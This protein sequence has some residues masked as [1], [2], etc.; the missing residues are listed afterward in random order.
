MQ[1]RSE[2]TRARW[3]KR[4]IGGSIGA[5]VLLTAT[6]AQA[7]LFTLSGNTPPALS[8]SV[9]ADGITLTITGQFRI[10]PSWVD[11]N[12]TQ[13]PGGLGLQG[14]GNA[15]LDSLAVNEF[16][17][18]SITGLGAGERLA[19]D[20][21][22]FFELDSGEDFS[23]YVDSDPA[24]VGGQTLGPG[25]APGTNPWVLADNLTGA[26][27]IASTSF[28][29]KVNGGGDSFRIRAITAHVVPEPASAT[30]LALGLAGLGVRR[31]TRI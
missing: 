4:L 26:Q 22:D 12:V 2:S 15:Q 30:L 31:R 5:A 27:R 18:F 19:I 25:F 8:K 9:T 24:G 23:F 13:R 7:T 29:V 28:A 11:A 1:S 14:G 16:L 6:A 17:L 3:L 20:T 10:G 21:I